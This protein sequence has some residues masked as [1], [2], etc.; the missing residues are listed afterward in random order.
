MAT[1]K[2]RVGIHRTPGALCEYRVIFDG[3][4]MHYASTRR[5]AERLAREIVVDIRDGWLDASV[6]AVS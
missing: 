5:D 3:M 4:T 2:N 6:R 1:H